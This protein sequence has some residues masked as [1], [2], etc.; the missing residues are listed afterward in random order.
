MSGAD[1]ALGAVAFLREIAGELAEI[2]R[3]SDYPLW[4]GEA[5]RRSISLRREAVPR[6]VDLETITAITCSTPWL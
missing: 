4:R 2:R 1:T 3:S 5:A 6:L